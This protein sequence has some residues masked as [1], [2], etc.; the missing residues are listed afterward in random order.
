MKFT[1]D[2]RTLQT[3]T[4]EVSRKFPGSRTDKTLR[5]VVAPGM[6]FLVASCRSGGA[7]AIDT[8]KGEC[9]V[10]RKRFIE[11]IKTFKTEHLLTLSAKGN[12]LSIQGFSMP[13]SNFLSTA[14]PPEKFD[15]FGSQPNV[16]RT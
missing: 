7:L 13:V 14:K 4:V 12:E 2:Q 15:W 9:T 10:D 3:M 16:S 11:V 1:L 6:V 8:E 5:L